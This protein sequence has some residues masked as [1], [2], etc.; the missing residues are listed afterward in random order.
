MPRWECCDSTEKT[1]EYC[2]SKEIMQKNTV[3]LKK[4]Y[5]DSKEEKGP[6]YCDSKEGILSFYGK[7]EKSSSYNYRVF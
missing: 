2:D 5:C 7:N 1:R 3:I 6:E 4:E